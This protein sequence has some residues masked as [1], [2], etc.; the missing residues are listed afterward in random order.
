MTLQLSFFHL[1]GVIP[2]N[3]NFVQVLISLLHSVFATVSHS[4]HRWIP[5]N[6]ALH[7]NANDTQLVSSLKIFSLSRDSNPHGF[8]VGAVGNSM[9]RLFPGT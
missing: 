4:I 1:F 3:K 8:T 9:D 7:R 5:A 6:L 2:T